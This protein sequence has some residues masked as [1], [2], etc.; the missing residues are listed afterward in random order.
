MYASASVRTHARTLILV[1]YLV[2]ILKVTDSENVNIHYVC[3]KS[4]FWP[5]PPIYNYGSKV[6]KKFWHGDSLSTGR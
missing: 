2:V 3:M 1:R 5:F 6:T 4:P